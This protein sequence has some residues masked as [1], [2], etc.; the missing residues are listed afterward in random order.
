MFKF[1]FD[2]IIYFN[3]RKKNRKK[4]SFICFFKQQKVRNIGIKKFHESNTNQIKK[5][6]NFFFM[7]PREQKCN[8]LQY[9][10]ICK[11]K[12]YLLLLQLLDLKRCDFD[13]LKTSVNS[14]EKKKFELY[15]KANCGISY[16]Q[17][18]HN[19]FF[20]LLFFFCFFFCF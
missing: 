15:V 16:F 8:K 9:A 14:Y 11:F 13:S 20:F 6:S 7:R 5:S 10:Y 12:V 19:I 1:H 3:I 18:M 2:F 17:R 4:K